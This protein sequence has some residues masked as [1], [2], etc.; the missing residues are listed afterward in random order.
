LKIRAGSQFVFKLEKLTFPRFFYKLA[1]T[2]THAAHFRHHQIGRNDLWTPIAKE[3]QLLYR[4]IV[5]GV[6]FS[7][8]TSRAIVDKWPRYGND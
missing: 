2:F 8:G 6:L 7:I 1:D 4:F 3:V 5:G